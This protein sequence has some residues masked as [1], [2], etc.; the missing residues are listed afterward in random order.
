MTTQP[1]TLAFHTLIVETVRER[2]VKNDQS[3]RKYDT[4][5]YVLITN[6]SIELRN[7]P[8][9]WSRSFAKWYEEYMKPKGAAEK[10]RRAEYTRHRGEILENAKVDWN[11]AHDLNVTAYDRKRDYF[12]KSKRTE[13]N[14]SPD[15]CGHE[16]MEYIEW[17][18][19]YIQ[20]MDAAE[21][22]RRSDFE[23]IRAKLPDPSDVPY[24]SMT[25][26]PR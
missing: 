22:K 12:I 4:E 6:K 26:A 9:G 21:A 18:K 1:T 19:I 14:Y 13:L 7:P 20:P 2:D 16:T 24:L 25:A 11:K 8:G 17:F 3:I 23:V 10:T 5:R 15:I